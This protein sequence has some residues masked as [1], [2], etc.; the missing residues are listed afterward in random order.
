M[1]REHGRGNAHQVQDTE[2][3]LDHGDG[4]VLFSHVTA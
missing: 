1:A 2:V 3:A 4:G